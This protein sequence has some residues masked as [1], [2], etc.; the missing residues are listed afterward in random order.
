[1]FDAV[2]QILSN[3]F[4]TPSIPADPIVSS[5]E[6][7]VHFTSTGSSDSVPGSKT[8]PKEA[9]GFT[10]IELLVVI[11][12]IAILIALLLPAV[13]QAR[14]AARRL[15]C[16]NNLKQLGIAVHNY[17]EQFDY[18]VPRK[19]QNRHSWMALLLPQV[20][21]AN[22]QDIY[23]FDRPWDHNVNQDSI[24]A[25]MPV[26]LCPSTAAAANHLVDI[27]GGKI[28]STTDYGPPNGVI[29]S[30]FFDPP[31]DASGAISVKT[32]SIN[33]IK[34]GTIH[35]LLFIEDAGRPEH[36]VNGKKGPD[37]SNNG[38]GNF[39]VSGG[40]VLGAAWADPQNGLPLH[41]F[42]YDGLSC[43]GPC[44]INCTNN[45][46]AYS[47]HPG[48]IQAV[49]VDGHVQFISENIHTSIYVALITARGGE[50]VGEF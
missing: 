44:A 1:M 39:N 38:C 4:W 12:I 9:R 30:E 19:I 49:F 16:K 40:I 18:M 36:W 41:G 26:L 14:E 21:Q 3:P 6:T 20:D 47:F 50:V 27:G 35:T 24:S 22:V 31:G 11:A 28:A 48:G 15:S 29:R 25:V 10:L 43:P 45:N 8:P 5:R 32:T 7:I 33:S 13:Q 34:D 17:L 23:D 46:E 37:N 42:T 2:I